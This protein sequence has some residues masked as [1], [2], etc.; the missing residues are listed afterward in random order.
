[1]YEFDDLPAKQGEH[2]L[3]DEADAGLPTRRRPE[4]TVV[5]LSVHV[6]LEERLING[7]GMGLKGSL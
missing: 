2:Q 4:N 5:E 6:A 3:S 7:H 1:L